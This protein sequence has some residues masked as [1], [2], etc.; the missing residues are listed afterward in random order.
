VIAVAHDRVPGPLARRLGNAWHL[1]RANP[2]LLIGA[3][4]VGT[5]TLTALFA[6]LI[7]PF[8]PEQTHANAILHAPSSTYLL[9]TDTTG[10]DILSRVIYAPRTDL[11]LAVLATAL[12][13]GIGL[14]VGLIAGYYSNFL[15]GVL[16][17]ANDI[18]QAFPVFVLGMALV[19]LSGQQ[20]SNV[21]VAIAIVQAPIYV[22]LVRS[23]VVYVKE[24][25]FVESAKSI[26]L[27]DRAIM[28]RHLLP[29]AA[30]PVLSMSSVTI[31][32]AMLLTA[33]LS[34]VGAGVRVPTP[35]WGSMIS[36]GSP[37][38]IENGDWWL[39]IPP[40]LMLAVT[41]MGFS[42]IGDSLS[43]LSDPRRRRTSLRTPAAQR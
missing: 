5:V 38:L 31:G 17:R 18:L 41:V 42:M 28:F 24:R 36:I 39:S 15:T 9:G 30:G 25:A 32:T 8:N 27:S 37:A 26:G 40:G 7:A 3:L 11:T 20:I 2:K 23:Q 29:N 4:I 34:F 21:V 33:G 16:M 22:R 13:V 43:E 1:L 14:P 19:V 12:A 35:E 6:P 10:M